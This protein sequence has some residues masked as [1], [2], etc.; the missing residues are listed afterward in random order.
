MTVTVTS[1]QNIHPHN[2]TTLYTN[3]INSSFDIW[4]HTWTTWIASRNGGLSALCFCA[5][6]GGGEYL[7]NFTVDSLLLRLVYSN[8][9]LS[10]NLCDLKL[11]KVNLHEAE[12]TTIYRSKYTR[13]KSPQNFSDPL[14]TFQYFVRN[15]A[16]RVLKANQK[17][18]KK[19]LAGLKP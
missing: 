6:G 9:F 2:P 5:G 3:I 12:K 8:I 18:R 17:L 19:W 11:L 7:R 4:T 13:K 16:Y 14:H 10:L 15:L 1:K